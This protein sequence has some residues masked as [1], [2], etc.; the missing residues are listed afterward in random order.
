VT[1]QEEY[2]LEKIEKI[3]RTTIPEL[4]IPPGVKIEETP[5][6][7]SQEMLKAI[8]DQRKKEDPTFQGAFH[9]KKAKN[10]RG[11]FKK[12]KPSAK[13]KK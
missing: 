1:S 10:A 8:D 3:I 9:E 2:H 5:F 4:E 11:D 12:K 7:E 6:E 13:R